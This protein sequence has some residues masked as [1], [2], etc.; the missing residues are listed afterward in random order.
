MPIS[1]MAPPAFPELPPLAGVRLSTAAGGSKYIGRDDLLL[2]QF[3]RDTQVAG[4]FTRS[5]T[6]GAP[7]RWCRQQLGRGSSRALLVNAGNAN[8]FTGHIGEAHVRQSCEAVAAAL[9]CQPEDVM[10][11]STGV[12]GE[13]LQLDKITPQIP[14]LAAAGALPG[15]PAA[16]KAIMTTDTFAKGATRRAQIDGATV[17]INGIAKGSGM[18]EPD[19]ATMLAFICTDANIP[20]PLLQALLAAANRDSFNAI[21][22]DSDTSTSDT[23]LLF[24]TRQAPHAP[25]PT[26]EAPVLADFSRALRRLMTDLALQVVRDGEGATKLIQ[27]EVTGAQHPQAARNVA[28]AIANSPLVKTAI[29]G[30]DANW[31]RVVMAVGK[32]GEKVDPERLIIRIGGVQITAQE[33]V[34][35]DY[36]E[37]PVAAHLQQSQVLLQV[38]LGVGAGAATVWGCDLTHEYIR[39]NGDYRS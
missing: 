37:T 11:A 3:C 13:P 5:L 23:C 1:P 39:I 38:D 20:A 31:G 34:L 26:A 6:A 17:T 33:R 30:A 24:A 29:A 2:M 10:V 35:A 9:D 14:A 28:R 25:P 27:V 16:A 12:I 7:V 32:A 22:V 36:D 4:V 8:V 18:I 19:M 15:W 21:T